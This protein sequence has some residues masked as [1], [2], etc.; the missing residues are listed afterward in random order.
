MRA[1]SSF[2]LSGFALKRQAHLL[3]H[4]SQIISAFGQHAV[5]CHSSALGGRAMLVR[6]QRDPDVSSWRCQQLAAPVFIR[7]D[8]PA[9]TRKRSSGARFD[10]RCHHSPSKFVM[11]S[12]TGACCH[13]SG[14]VVVPAVMVILV[15]QSSHFI[16]LND[17]I[18]SFQCLDQSSEGP[19]RIPTVFD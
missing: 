11:A 1:V 10:Q 12:G 15:M 8:V 7:A 16:W 6:C 14:S 13:E 5:A 18:Q 3:A 17:I 4:M 2:S 9:W 19:K